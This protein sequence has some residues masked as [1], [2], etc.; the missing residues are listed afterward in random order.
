MEDSGDLAEGPERKWKGSASLS[1]T[2]HVLDL[3]ISR[4]KLNFV[5]QHKFFAFNS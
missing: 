2:P 4:H 5:S 3:G 1:L